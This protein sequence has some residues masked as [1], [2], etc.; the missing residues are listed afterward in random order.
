M[1]LFNAKRKSLGASSISEDVKLR[2]SG[3][4]IPIMLK[5]SDSNLQR[6][7]KKTEGVGELLLGAFTFLLPVVLEARLYSV[8]WL[9]NPFLDS[10][11]H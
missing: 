6:K 5:K 8:I 11:G 10:I 7:N 9:C 1:F 3:A 2:N 4:H